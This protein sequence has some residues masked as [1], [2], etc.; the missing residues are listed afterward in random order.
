MFC[1]LCKN[2]RHIYIEGKGWTKCKC[3]KELHAQRIL[4]NS[5]LPS[6]L[7]I[8]DSEV[9]IQNSPDRKRLG[10]AI[11][12]EVKEF[13]KK[14]F[15][16]Y[17]NSLDKDRAAAIITRY[18]VLR[19]QEIETVYY[20]DLNSI[21]EEKFEG[22]QDRPNYNNIDILILSIGQEIT[23]NAHKSTLY[24]LLYSRILGEKFTIVLSA[25]PKSRI[26]QIYQKQ[27]DDLF[28]ENFEF[29]EC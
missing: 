25:F 15:F 1:E 28:K 12:K 7:Q 20:N 19:H 23:N 3:V 21:T 2:K 18:L 5:N 24:N 8:I 13:N 14:P 6:S 17:S 11:S 9:F 4:S 22:S 26:L 27:I 16:I 29:Y 10:E